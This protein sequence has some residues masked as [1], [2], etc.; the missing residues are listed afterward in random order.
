MTAEMKLPEVLNL[1]LRL[2]LAQLSPELRDHMINEIIT[3]IQA[4]E[5]KAFEAGHEIDGEWLDCG[6][7]YAS[8]E[9]YLRSADYD[10]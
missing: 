10:K 3:F 1:Q 5:R 6:H 8:F 7:L 4:R 2:A 9:D